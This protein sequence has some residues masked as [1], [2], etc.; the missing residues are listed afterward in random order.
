MSRKSSIILSSIVILNCISSFSEIKADVI[1]LKNEEI[2]KGKVISK[3]SNVITF[4]TDDNKIKQIKE[5]QIAVIEFI[6]DKI[7]EIDINGKKIKGIEI[8]ETKEGVIVKT[9]LGEKIVSKNQIKEISFDQPQ[10]EVTTTNTVTNY[11]QLTNEV[12]LTNI[13][14]ITNSET[15]NKISVFSSI[16]INYDFSNISFSFFSGMK[17]TIHKKISLSVY[18]GKIREGITGGYGIEYSP[19]ELITLKLGIG[20][21]FS[22]NTTYLLTLGTDI[23]INLFSQEFYIPLNVIMIK[24][25]LSLHL[26]LGITL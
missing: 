11:I 14:N 1:I 4:K 7:V 23:I 8:N 22:Q 9:A 16:G 10:R 13:I 6:S 25:N 15:N 24:T 20:G 5:N 26:G 18:L 17:I 19:I 2:L 12:I 21:F 3:Q